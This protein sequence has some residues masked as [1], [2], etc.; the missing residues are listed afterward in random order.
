[1]PREA[2][3]RLNAALAEAGEEPFANPRN[4]AA[5]AVRQKD[6]AVTR[7]RPLAIFLYH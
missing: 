2:F 4:A 1:M 3:Q 7:S 6:P 5:G